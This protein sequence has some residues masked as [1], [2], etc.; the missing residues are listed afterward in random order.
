[1]RLLNTTKKLIEI[2]NYIDQEAGIDIAIKSR[3]RSIVLYRVLYYKLALELTDESLQNIG[4]VLNRDHATVLH[5]RNKNFEYMMSLETYRNLYK[6]YMELYKLSVV[7]LAEDEDKE[8][9]EL[10]GQVKNQHEIIQ[11]L[12]KIINN[13]GLTK[14]EI[15][16]RTLTTEQKIDY[17]E[18]VSLFL[19]SLTWKQQNQKLEIINC[20]NNVRLAT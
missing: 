17:D 16:Y 4:E 1:M 11:D 18:R 2:K 20:S 13:I 6:K 8:M 7:D 5:S 9:T 19:K 15:K 3:K 12:E 10:R 14:N